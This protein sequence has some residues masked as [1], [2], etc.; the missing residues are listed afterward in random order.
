MS[1]LDVKIGNW[2]WIWFNGVKMSIPFVFC[3]AD[4]FRTITENDAIT[5]VDY[6]AVTQVRLV[7]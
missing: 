3:S 4:C 5:T 6:S 7:R 1:K 2:Y